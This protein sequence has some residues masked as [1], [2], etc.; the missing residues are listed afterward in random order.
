MEAIVKD[1]LKKEEKKKN[2][3]PSEL[4]P[5][6]SPLHDCP[7]WYPF[8]CRIHLQ[9]A[10][11]NIEAGVA[12]EE[13]Y[14]LK[15]ITVRMLYDTPER[16]QEALDLIVKAKTL[17]VNPEYYPQIFKQ[18]GITLLRLGK[19]QEA[20]SPFQIYLQKLE[21]EKEKPQFVLDEIAWTKKM[22]FETKSMQINS[23]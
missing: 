2:A 15:G 13:D 1:D 10:D 8:Y 3:S 7:F 23:Q 9:L 12:T 16:N 21:A 6:P 18:E 5:H 14:L 20:I 17:N 22:I 19:K 11:R 4:P